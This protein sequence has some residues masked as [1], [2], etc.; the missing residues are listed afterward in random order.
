MTVSVDYR[1]TLVFCE[2]FEALIFNTN[3][4]FNNVFSKI[5]NQVYQFQNVPISFGEGNITFS[6][7]IMTNGKYD[8]WSDI[9]DV[10]L[11][12]INQIF[13]FNQRLTG[14]ATGTIH[15]SN[16]LNHQ[17]FLSNFKIIDGNI[18]DIIFKQCRGNISFRKNRLLLNEFKIDTDIGNIEAEGW[19]TSNGINDD[20][21][22]HNDS[23]N[24]KINFNSFDF[25]TL[26]RY[27]PW[28]LHRFTPM[29]K[30]RYIP[31]YIPMYIL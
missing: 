31:R 14:T 18:D 30:P 16:L 6:G 1:A 20:F 4:S 22:R 25:Q 3:I 27:L 24:M 26:N 11:F 28:Y 2:K 21:F 5:N 13:N 15:L 12:N 10:E 19:L 23:L 8:I 29:Y 7:E 9:K 17:N